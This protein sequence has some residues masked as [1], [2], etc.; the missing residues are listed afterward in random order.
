MLVAHMHTQS[1]G[2]E[3]AKTAF[4][5]TTQKTS[6]TKASGLCPFYAV[7]LIWAVKCGNELNLNSRCGERSY[8]NDL[9]V[10]SLF[11]LI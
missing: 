8:S 9:C 6:V 10:F 1:K 3:N 7:N 2:K 4:S 11:V 5:A